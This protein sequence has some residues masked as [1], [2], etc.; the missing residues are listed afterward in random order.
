MTRR[1]PRPTPFPYTTLFR[2]FSPDGKMLATGSNDKTVRL[3]DVASGQELATLSGHAE[4]VSSVAFSPDSAM[5]ASASWDKTVRVWNRSEEH[6]S[7]LQ[8][9]RDLVCRL[10]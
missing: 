5:L 4:V 9:R 10:L 6:T 8:S 2:S 7:E 1:R 3:W